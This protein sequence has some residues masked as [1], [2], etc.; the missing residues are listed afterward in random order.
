MAQRRMRGRHGDPC[1]AG[2]CNGAGPRRFPSRCRRC[3]PVVSLSR[4]QR[5]PWGAAAAPAP[6]GHQGSLLLSQPSLLVLCRSKSPILSRGCLA[7]GA[8]EGRSGGLLLPNDFHLEH[9]APE[10]VCAGAKASGRWLRVPG[11]PGGNLL[12]SSSAENALGVTT[13]PCVLG[14]RWG[15]LGWEG[16]CQQVRDGVLPTSSAL[17]RLIWNAV[18]SSGVLRT[19]WT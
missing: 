8:V 13:V 18:S 7:E 15:I 9:A 12:D 10:G 19:G 16:H 5:R 14:P 17:L 11:R 3:A 1:R 2:R 6:P 4:P